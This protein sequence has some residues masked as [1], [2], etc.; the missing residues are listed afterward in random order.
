VLHP[1]GARTIAEAV[2]GAT[3][4]ML[5]GVGHIPML[6]APEPTAAHFADFLDGHPN[7]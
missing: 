4:R 2:P 5:P 6:E 1:S 3:V 7:A